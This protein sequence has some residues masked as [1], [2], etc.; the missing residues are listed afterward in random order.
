MERSMDGRRT[1]RLEEHAEL[2]LV[3]RARG[4]PPEGALVAVTVA[5]WCGVE[6]KGVSHVRR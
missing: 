1:E 3:G 4:V 5:D 6:G 2:G